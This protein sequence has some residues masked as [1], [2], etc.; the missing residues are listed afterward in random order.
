MILSLDRRGSVDKNA[1]MSMESGRL[2]VCSNIQY[3][4]GPKIADTQTRNIIARVAQFRDPHLT[5]WRCPHIDAAS[6][7]ESRGCTR[8][9]VAAHECCQGAQDKRGKR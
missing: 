2:S 6:V 1:V 3:T 4:I 9:G 8:A 7:C 5:R